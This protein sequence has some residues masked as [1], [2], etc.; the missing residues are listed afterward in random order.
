MVAGARHFHRE[1]DSVF[2]KATNIPQ[3]T[4]ER[5]H[6]GLGRGRVKILLAEEELR[7]ALQYVHDT[8]LLPGAS[9]GWHPHMDNEEVYYIVSGQGRMRVDDEEQT[10]GPGDVIVCHPGSHHSLE[11]TGDDELRMI[12]IAAGRQAR[13]EWGE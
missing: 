4:A 5:I 10:V 3:Y 2:K 11:N 12:V 8:T 6:D 13:E 9:V 7:S 1:V